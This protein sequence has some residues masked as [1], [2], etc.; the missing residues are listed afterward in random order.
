MKLITKKT[1]HVPIEKPYD[2]ARA[3][4]NTAF[5]VSVIS[6]TTSSELATLVRALQGKVRPFAVATVEGK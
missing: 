2:F 6:I 5:Q 4:T 1:V 3:M